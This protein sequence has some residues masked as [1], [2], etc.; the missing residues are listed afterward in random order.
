MSTARVRRDAGHQA[1]R[2]ELPEKLVNIFDGPALYRCAF[3]GRGSG[4]SRGFATMAAVHGLR[5]AQANETGVILCAREFQNSLDE[6][7]MAEVKAAI[8]TQA[9]LAAQYEV[10]EKYIRTRDGKIEFVFAGLRRNIESVKST[11]R[12]RLLWVDE[13]EPVS[14]VAWMKAIP[15]VREEGAEIWVSWNPERRQSATNKRFRINPPANSKLVELNWRDNPWFPS[16]LQQI[17]LEDKEKRPDQYEHIW[18]GAYASA[19]AGA[20]YSSHLAE[21]GRDGRIGG[22][23]RDPLLPIK[24]FCD[25]GGSGNASDAFAMWG[26]QWVQREVRVLHYYEAISEPLATHIQWLRDNNLEKAEIYLPHDGA[27]K[28]R[29]YDV[30]FE[31]AFRQAGF[32]VEVIPNQGRGAARARIEAGR[33][34]FPACWFNEATTESGREA[35]A[36]YHER[37]SED[38]RDVGLGPLHDWCLTADTEIITR[39]GIRMVSE[40]PQFGEVLTLCGWKPY[41]DPRIT[42]RRAPLVAVEFSDGSTVRCTPEHMFLTENGWISA[43]SLQTGTPIQSGSIPSPSILTAVFTGFGRVTGICRAAARRCIE[44]HGRLR[45][46]RSRR[47]AT[48][49]IATA[50]RSIICSPIWNAFQPAGILAMPDINGR[51]AFRPDSISARPLDRRRLSGMLLRK[52]GYGT[53]D[54]PWLPKAG[55]SGSEK[56]GFAFSAALSL[57]PLFAR[58]LINKF[59]APAPARQRH[60]GLGRPRWSR[61]ESIVPQWLP[62]DT[63]PATAPPAERGL[64]RWLPRPARKFIAAQNAKTSRSALKGGNTWLRVVRVRRLSETADV[65]CLTVPEY[66]HFA[67]AN[68][69]ISHNSSHGSDAFGLMAVAY[70][71]PRGRP[72]QI[73]YP[74]MG[75]V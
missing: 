62:D 55:Q 63:S 54:T 8:E 3:G 15:T 50:I 72:K 23:M 30:S 16:V 17:R 68:G 5:C 69:A 18:E 48:S 51:L 39:D 4:K 60:T 27:T 21:A 12:I 67:L 31:S 52:A 70:E 35:L 11:A 14:E 26:V 10:G 71:A 6:S 13:A 19:H 57:T 1:G 29:I 49:T 2:I 73:R 7:S 32:K 66:H 53:A 24:V 45:L 64:M 58:T 43:Q 22:V 46:G 36:W 41:H 33:R 44:Q 75:F 42:R 37:K 59:T 28:D 20:Y 61:H 38:I 65:W 56:S 34:I 40:M 25:L 47:V 74:E 9:W